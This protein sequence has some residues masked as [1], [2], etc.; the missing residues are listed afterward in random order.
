MIVTEIY[1]GQGFGNQLWCYVVTRVIARDRN[2]EFGIKSP[3]KIKGVDFMNL[4]FGKA[5]IG[6][7]GPEG[8]PPRSLPEGIK[9]YY[10][11]KEIVHPLN[12]VDIRMHDKNLLSIR[13]NTKID[14]IMQDEQYI[15]HRKNEIRDWLRVKK[16]Y[17]CYDYSNDNICVINFR[18]GEY[19][20][21][22]NVFLTQK[23][24]DDAMEHMLKINKN[25]K[26]VVITDDVVTARRFFPKF[27][28]FHFS[29]SKDY[30]IIKNAKYLI[31]SNSSFAFFPAWLNENLKFCI[32]PKYWSQYNTSDGFWGCSYN[33]T[34]DWMYL[35]RNGKLND[36]D[37]CIREQREYI[38]KHRE[39][40]TQIKLK[41]NFLVV[42]NYYNDISWIP[43]YTDDYIIYDQ[44]EIEMY[45]DT[46]DKNKVIKNDHLG[47]NIYDYCTYII[48][49]YENLPERVL[50]AT[51]NI[52]PRHIP[53]EYFD[54]LMNNKFFTP[55]EYW[56][57]HKEYY[58]KGFLIC[59]FSSDGGFC[60][61]NNSHYLN[62][63]H[64]TKYFHNYND[65]L[66]FCFIDPVIPK[67]IRFAPGANYIVP[68][69]N[70]LKIPKIF[71]ENL[72]VF[73]SHCATAIPGESH[74]IERAFHTIWN[75]NFEINPN[76][77]KPIDNSFVAIPK[78]KDST[79][80]PTLK[81]RIVNK[82]IRILEKI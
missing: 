47:H 17:E 75:S 82:I 60:E 18:G 55:F 62:Q 30:I 20:A 45:P 29:I 22:K 5:V 65:F 23:Y 48:N 69:E 1:N 12:G 54:R 44:S 79:A 68:R 46:I 41:N 2:Y 8:G 6:G 38:D 61:I 58:K 56:K 80:K 24:W 59:F 57:K 39:Y 63:T 10:N 74:I 49:N 11:E 43:E 3:E 25:F 70:I 73:V 13:D 76:M 50:F 34:K 9:Y 81:D 78:I 67:Y 51:G 72:K 71:Y 35:D 15:I 36:Y 28:V 19:M 4:D 77:L 16:E 27:D 66:R 14:G 42:S 26:F 37:K 52:F 7:I 64:P 53:K 32:A 31:L 40:Y 21:I 33:I